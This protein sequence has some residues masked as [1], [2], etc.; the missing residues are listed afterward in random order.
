MNRA[1]D[2]IVVRARHR[3]DLG[4]VDSLMASIASVGLLNPV[5]VDSENV[6][7]AG[8]RRLI[9]CRR[10][11]WK[12]IPVTVAANF[13]DAVSRLVAERD[14]N[15]CR[16]DMSPSELV[17]LGKALEELERPKARERQ[18]TQ[19]Y[20]RNC[21]SAEQQLANPKRSSA[22][23]TRTIVAGAIGMSPAVYGRAKHVVEAAKDETLPEEVREVA[24]KAVR[25]MD[26]T[27][28]VTTQY[29]RVR[30]AE[31]GE[32]PPQVKRASYGLNRTPPPDVIAE[33]AIQTI[34]GLAVAIGD[35]NFDGVSVTD[36]QMKQLADGLSIINRMKRT[37]ALGGNSA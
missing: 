14:E 12:E 6:L 24:T 33:R 19:D 31:K 26:R 29:D 17:S 7:L 4:E 37:L 1:I 32:E 23:Y 35:C 2:A 22:G 20:G 27:G 18:A 8:E 16:K 25:E 34:N 10:L 11:G 36:A 3:K 15:T 9:A 30:A 28:V 5:T 13:D 21:C